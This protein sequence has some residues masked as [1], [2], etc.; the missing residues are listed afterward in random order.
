MDRRLVQQPITTLVP[1]IVW[2]NTNFPTYVPRC[3]THQ[4]SDG[5]QP[6]DS[7]GGSSSK[8][9]PLGKP[10]IMRNHVLCNLS[11]ATTKCPLELVWVAN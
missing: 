6:K 2:V 4:P 11:Y 7:H 3:S 1:T 8:G 9:D 10:P 5:G